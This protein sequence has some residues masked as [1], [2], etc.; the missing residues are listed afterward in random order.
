MSHRRVNV[1]EP[2][3]RAPVDPHALQEIEAVI[4]TWPGDDARIGLLVVGSW[5]AG[6]TLTLR[7]A[8]LRLNAYQIGWL[9]QV[10]KEIDPG[11]PTS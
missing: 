4:A 8:W 9:A 11:L 3:A 6:D 2:R 10:L 5:L 7:R 1:H